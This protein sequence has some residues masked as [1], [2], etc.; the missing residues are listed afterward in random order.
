[1]IDHKIKIT[2]KFLSVTFFIKSSI[3][4]SSPSPE[5]IFEA[6]TIDFT[7]LVNNKQL[8]PYPVLAIIFLI[9]CMP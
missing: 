3:N 7:L 2:S 5:I 4:N 6:S 9:A 1:M 8:Y